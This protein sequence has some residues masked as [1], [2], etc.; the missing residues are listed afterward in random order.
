MR[1]VIRSLAGGGGGGREGGVMLALVRAAFDPG[2][3]THSPETGTD[4]PLNRLLACSDG[5]V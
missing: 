2:G 4:I 3:L 1:A 5:S